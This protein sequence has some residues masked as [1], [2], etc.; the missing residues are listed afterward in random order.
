MRLNT[1]LVTTGDGGFLHD[2]TCPDKIVLF[3]D[4]HPQDEGRKFRAFELSADRYL[5]S[6]GVDF[7]KLDAVG[8]IY[9][10]TFDPRFVEFHI[11][12]VISYRH[13]WSRSLAAKVR[14]LARIINNKR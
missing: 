13:F 1:L 14:P 5:L 12:R 4:D 11:R 10:P 6:K 2:D 8:E 3:V 9:P 7:T